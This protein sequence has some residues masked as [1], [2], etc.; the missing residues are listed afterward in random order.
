MEKLRKI[1][2]NF[3]L[4]MTSSIPVPRSVCVF[5]ILFIISMF[6]TAISI[7]TMAKSIPKPVKVC[8]TGEPIYI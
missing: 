3:H 8:P 2:I 6:I 1:A 5:G 4:W 7:S